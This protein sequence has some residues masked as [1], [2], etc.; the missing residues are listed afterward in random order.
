VNS[1][2]TTLDLSGSWFF[3]VE[4]M[5]FLSKGFGNPKCKL[6]T[7]KLNNSELRPQYFATI[8]RNLQTNKFLQHLEFNGN[9]L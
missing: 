5:E 6:T 7:L 9:A 1:Q 8:A 3:G 2:I 4:G